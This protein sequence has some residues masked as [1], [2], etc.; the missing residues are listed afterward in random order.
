MRSEI[1]EKVTGILVKVTFRFND[2]PWT[3]D[4][5]FDTYSSKHLQA[6]L[7]SDDFRRWNSIY[8]RVMILEA[9]K[10]AR[11]NLAHHECGITILSTKIVERW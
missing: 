9:R 2:G 5:Y 10:A 11:K 7:D 4:M 8:N 3:K 1:A 6:V